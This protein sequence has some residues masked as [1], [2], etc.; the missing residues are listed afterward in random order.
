MRKIIVFAIASL[1]CSVSFANY[2]Q[3]IEQFSFDTTIGEYPV[4]YYHFGG[5]V[6]LNSKLKLIPA[7]NPTFGAI[8]LN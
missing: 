3:K 4:A 2:R 1:L 6:G 8:F 5:S 7:S